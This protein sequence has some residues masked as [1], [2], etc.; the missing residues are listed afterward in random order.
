MDSRYFHFYHLLSAG[1]DARDFLY[2][3]PAA[4]KLFITDKQHL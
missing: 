3:F 4:Y 2:C 1:L